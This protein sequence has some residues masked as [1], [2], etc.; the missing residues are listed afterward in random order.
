M[1][2]GV[3]K[4]GP[5]PKTTRIGLRWPGRKFAHE[6]REQLRGDGDVAPL[7]ACR[8]EWEQVVR[9]VEKVHRRYIYA[10]WVVRLVSQ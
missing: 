2:P 1:A 8:D 7:I 3:A 10:G 9:E 5:C 6:V 4:Q